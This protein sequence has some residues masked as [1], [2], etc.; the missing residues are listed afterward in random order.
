M[1]MT[2]DK[3]RTFLSYQNKLKKAISEIEEE[4]GGKVA[5]Q[6]LL[7]ALYNAKWYFAEEFTAEEIKRMKY[8]IASDFP[9]FL[10]T[11]IG[12][13]Q[14]KVECLNNECTGHLAAIATRDTRIEDCEKE[15]RGYRSRLSTILHNLVSME[16]LNDERINGALSQF[17]RN[18]I[19]M[20]KL[21][22]G[23]ALNE[24]ELKVVKSKITN[25]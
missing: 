19:I 11:C 22:Q 13:L 15:I 3:A 17:S 4:F 21:N 12:D 10:E 6:E 14:H 25:Y 20:E 7:D 9:I 8:N 18:R 5:E 16:L 1:A 24:E 2:N 23:I